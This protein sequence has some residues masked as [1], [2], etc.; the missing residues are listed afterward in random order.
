MTLAN[1]RTTIFIKTDFEGIHC[2]PNAPEEVAFLRHPHR[3][4]FHVRIDLEVTHSDRD[5]EFIMF[6]REIDAMIA[7]RITDMQHRSCEMICEILL[8]YVTTKYTQ[9]DCTVEVSED[10]ENGATIVFKVPYQAAAPV[11]FIS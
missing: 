10:G 5:V 3:H 8:E 6:R 2:Y 11:G 1:T 4:R 9:R 7:E